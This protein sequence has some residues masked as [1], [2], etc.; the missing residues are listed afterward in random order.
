MGILYEYAVKVICGKADGEILAPGRYWT[1]INVH[2]PANDRVRF[3]KKVAIA[4]PSEKPGP[5]S[6]FFRATLGPDEA[7]EIDCRDI[8]E[9]AQYGED[10][11][12]GF[13]VIQSET[14]LDIVAVYTAAGANEAI[15]TMDIERVSPRRIRIGLPD[16]V[17]VPDENESFCRRR[18]GN[19]IVTV[20]NQGAFGAGPSMTTVDFGPHGTV[21]LPTP[22]LAAGA[23]VDL[24]FPIPFGCFDPDCHFR[25]TVDSTGL[26][27][28]SDEGNNTA[29]GFC[30]G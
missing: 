19:L 22:A 17:P 14:E 4:L 2:N 8:R 18:D 13:V 28:E 5:V 11:L 12:K 10:L 3:R 29:S 1:A 9:H 20:R 21:T 6:K 25:I 15:E 23:S 27:V 26:I 16:L 7:F 24:A 30:L